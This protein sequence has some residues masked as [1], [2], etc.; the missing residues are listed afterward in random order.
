[1]SARNGSEV[2]SRPQA[3]KFGYSIGNLVPKCFHSLSL[4]C[5]RRDSCGRKDVIES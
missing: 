3:R 1:M 4:G 5:Q 2:A